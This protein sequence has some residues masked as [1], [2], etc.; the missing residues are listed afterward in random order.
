MLMAVAAIV[1]KVGKMTGT[2]VT[3]PSLE[4]SLS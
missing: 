3:R 1:K 2:S 4:P